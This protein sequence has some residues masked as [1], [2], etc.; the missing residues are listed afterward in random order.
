MIKQRSRP[1]KDKIS[2]GADKTQKEVTGL[3]KKLNLAKQTDLQKIEKKVDK[4]TKSIKAI[5]KK[6]SEM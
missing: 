5:E 6:L 2:K 4:L 3:V 1:R